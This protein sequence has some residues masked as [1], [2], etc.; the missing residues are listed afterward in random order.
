MKAP[1]DTVA[2]L[3][4]KYPIGNEKGTFAFV[5]D[6]NTFYTYHPRGWHRGE[7][8]PISSDSLS[9]FFEIDTEFL[10]EGDILVYDS[11][12]KKFVVKSG[13]VWNKLPTGINGVL[14]QV[15]KF[16]NQ[17][18]AIPS[19]T[20]DSGVYFVNN[21]ALAGLYIVLG[22]TVIKIFNT[23][24]W[25]K[26]EIVQQ[27][28]DDTYTY[29]D[30]Q[31]NNL[32]QQIQNKENVGILKTYATY[33][34]MLADINSPIGDNGQPI[35][36]GQLVSVNNTEDDTQN[37]I[38]AYT[39]KGNNKSW[40]KRSDIIIP[41]DMARTGGSILTMQ[42]MDDKVKGVKEI[43]F[44]FVSEIDSDPEYTP[45]VVDN[46]GQIIFARKKDGTPIIPRLNE[47]MDNYLFRFYQD[48][49][50]V[51]AVMDNN[52]QVWWGVRND[53][54]VFQ[55]NQIEKELSDRLLTVISDREWEFAV[56]DKLN[57]VW[58]G[59]RYDSSIYPFDFLMN[60]IE[61]IINSS[62]NV[63]HGNHTKETS[64]QLPFPRSLARVDFVGDLTGIG[65]DDAVNV[66]LKFNDMQGNYF[67]KPIE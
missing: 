27:K 30:G 4:E 41:D 35:L 63:G 18:E 64:L 21:D 32:D 45:I 29:I 51:I 11:N 66:M 14:S 49:E 42:D 65:K 53:G 50:W 67:E 3:Y 2:Q 62:S 9:S 60:N 36:N 57:Q 16:L 26:K 59:V 54:S 6:K 34:A 31:V 33:A 43:I 56:V 8:K 55:N 48:K 1:V 61:D 19:T 5:H 28:I 15:T 39:I 17:T 10:Q 23:S 24:D 22:N 25:Y 20:S 38:Y 47:S 44:P 40:I 58:F 7:W 37:G 46:L 52:K 12:K 13:N